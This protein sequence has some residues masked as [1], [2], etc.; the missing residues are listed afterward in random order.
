MQAL[1]FSK[2]FIQG[3]SV[4][5]QNTCREQTLMQSRTDREMAEADNGAFSNELYLM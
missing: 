2:G 3:T 4:E 5:V 1:L